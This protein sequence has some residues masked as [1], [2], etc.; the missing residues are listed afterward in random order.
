MPELFDPAETAFLLDC[1]AEYIVG[2]PNV[3]RKAPTPKGPPTSLHADEHLQFYFDK[4]PGIFAR[5]FAADRYA[6]ELTRLRHTLDFLFTVELE[7]INRA[8]SVPFNGTIFH[9]MLWFRFD[10]TRYGRA[11]MRLGFRASDVPEGVFIE[12]EGREHQTIIPHRLPAW[13][14]PA[15]YAAI[16]AKFRGD[17]DRLA[18]TPLS[19]ADMISDAHR[20][21]Y[22]STVP[23]LEG[24]PDVIATHG[25]NAYAFLRLLMKEGAAQINASVFDQMK[26]GGAEPFDDQQ[27]GEWQDIAGGCLRYWADL[28]RDEPVTSLTSPQNF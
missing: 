4:L 21:A 23:G 15:G 10:V 27:I 5:L 13:W 7:I 28:K 22:T 6:P 17:L 11:Q 1:A 20:L 16:A 9:P 26:E 19:E 2:T 24:I 3:N 8:E 12:V 25:P 14:K 18:H